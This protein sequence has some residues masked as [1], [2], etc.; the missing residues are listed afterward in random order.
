MFFT[1]KYSW[2]LGSFSRYGSALI[3][4]ESYCSKPA[5]YYIAKAF[6]EH[7]ARG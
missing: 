6:I 4:D 5:Y 2:I 3:F 7:I 1:D